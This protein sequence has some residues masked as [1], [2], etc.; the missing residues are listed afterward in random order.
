MDTTHC[1]VNPLWG[2]LHAGDL[3]Q[4]LCC[5]QD[6]VI[7]FR[8]KLL[9]HCSRSMNFYIVWA[10]DPKSERGRL[11]IRAKGRSV[12]A[13]SPCGWHPHVATRRSLIASQFPLRS[14]ALCVSTPVRVGV[15]AKVCL[16]GR[17][18][19]QN[20]KRSLFDP[21]LSCIAARSACRRVAGGICCLRVAQ[22]PRCCCFR[23]S[24]DLA[25][26]AAGFAPL[27]L[28]VAQRKGCRGENK[29]LEKPKAFAA[30][31]RGTFVARVFVGKRARCC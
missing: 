28:C 10:L 17:L 31:L 2:V 12:M 1:G 18:A 6:F 8:R 7:P 4:R 16:G 30:L 27:F 23:P 13:P 22:S 19:R 5:K 9:S 29:I 14:F 21:K 26:S 24:S 20:C 25:L 11:I 15:P 3:A